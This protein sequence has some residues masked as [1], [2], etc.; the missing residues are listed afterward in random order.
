M[1]R[2]AGFQRPVGV[3]VKD[4]FIDRTEVTNQQFKE[5]V[6][7]GGY[8]KQSYWKHEFANNGAVLSWD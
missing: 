8:R 5:F 2:V 1:V 6:D 3:G 4:F 7:A